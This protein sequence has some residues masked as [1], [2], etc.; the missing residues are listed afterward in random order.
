MD[1]ILA[2]L[3]IAMVLSAAIGAGILIRKSRAAS[4]GDREPRMELVLLAEF[5]YRHDAELAVGY[6][7]DAGIDAALFVDDAGGAYFG[8]SFPSPARIMVSAEQA[9]E[10]R[11]V[12]ESLG[13]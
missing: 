1:E 12:L 13:I 9:E 3:G 10:A 8:I 5:G 6:L 4:V 11:E 7:K 2:L